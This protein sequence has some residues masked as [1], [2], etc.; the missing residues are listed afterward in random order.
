MLIRAKRKASGLRYPEIQDFR[1]RSNSSRSWFTP[2]SAARVGFAQMT[3]EPLTPAVKT[4][5][6]IN[7]RRPGSAPL[8]PQRTRSISS[9]LGP[10]DTESGAYLHLLEQHHGSIQELADSLLISV[11][12]C[13]HRRKRALERCKVQCLLFSGTSHDSNLPLRGW[14]NWRYQ[15]ATR[16]HDVGDDRALRLAQLWPLKLAAERQ[17]ISVRLTAGQEGTSCMKPSG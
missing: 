14:R 2:A 8:I 13:Y 16:G 3:G 7:R 17:E 9:G 6:A 10:H 12:Y 11:S 15:R 5:I 1:I 4:A